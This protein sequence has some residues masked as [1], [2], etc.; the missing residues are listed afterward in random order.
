ME[1]ILRQQS[2]LDQ[3]ERERTAIIERHK[4]FLEKAELQGMNPDS[5]IPLLGFADLAISKLGKILKGKRI[6]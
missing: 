3:T 2:N 6:C 4:G 1:N 5:L